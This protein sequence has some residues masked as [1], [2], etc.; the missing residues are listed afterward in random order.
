MNRLKESFIKCKQSKSSSSRPYVHIQKSYLRKCDRF[1]FHALFLFFNMKSLIIRFDGCCCFLFLF[2]LILL[3]QS[4]NLIRVHYLFVYFVFYLFLLAVK[5]IKMCSTSIP[6]FFFI[7]LNLFIF[8]LD[9]V[10]S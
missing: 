1:R 6:I 8:N 5:L 9:F 3:F 7:S 2:S 10:F 4:F